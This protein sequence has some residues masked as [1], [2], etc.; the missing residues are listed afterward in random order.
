MRASP[1][2]RVDHPPAG[3][4]K[5]DVDDEAIRATL[6]ELRS[7]LQRRSVRN[8]SSARSSSMRVTTGSN[9]EDVERAIRMLDRGTYGICETCGEP[10]APERLEAYP[11]S[12]Y[13]LADQR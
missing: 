13:C 7:E 11:A 8:P 2:P 1:P 10:I 4:Y 12:R 9:L 6:E 3:E 5:Q